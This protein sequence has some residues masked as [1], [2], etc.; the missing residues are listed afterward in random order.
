MYNLRVNT[1]S[2]NVEVERLYAN[3]FLKSYVTVKPEKKKKNSLPP[4]S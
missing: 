2:P 3:F 1:K 4:H